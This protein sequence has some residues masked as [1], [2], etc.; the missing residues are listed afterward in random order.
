MKKTFILI[1]GFV[2]FNAFGTPVL[3]MN[4]ALSALVD[5]LPFIT[6]ESEFKAKEN[7]KRI[8]SSITELE[9]AFKSAKHDKLMKSD[10]FAPSYAV[11]T[12]ELSDVNRAFKKNQ[13]DFAHWRLKE[14][15]SHCLDCHTRLPPEMASSFQSGD[16]QLDKSKFSNPYNLGVAQ[17]IVR[18]A[19]DAKWTFTNVIDESL[20]KNDFRDTKQALKQLL[21][22]D[23][24][25]LKNP[26][27]LIPPLKLYLKKEKLPNEIA[28]MIKSWI[29]RIEYW[30]KKKLLSKGLETDTEVKNFI[31]QELTPLRKDSPLNDGAS[32]D[33]LVASGLLSNYFFSHPKSSLAPELNFWLGWSEKF[34]KR[35][36]FF[37][38]GDYFLKQCVRRYPKSSI[39]KDCLKEYKESVIFDFSGS[40]G[41]HIPDDVQ[42]ELDE[43]NKT[44][45][46]K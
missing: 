34:L 21:L 25:I 14:I 18:R 37:G 27:N 31:H 35:E 32:V 13:K 10:L 26:G 46:K 38:S 41:T 15:T 19:V 4:K 9:T 16:L 28:E 24:K 3:Q 12:E 44:I 45:E 39:A 5:L 8:S 40:S 17:L 42:A 43:L 2:C 11:I 33:L 22:I 7:D 30:E 20:L 36:L 29:P 6:N 1:F 23:V